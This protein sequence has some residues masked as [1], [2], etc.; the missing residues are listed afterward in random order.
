MA[1]RAAGRLVVLPRPSPVEQSP[2]AKVLAPDSNIRDQVSSVTSDF[3]ACR[4]GVSKPS[5]NQA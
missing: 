1:E 3:A 4:S 5:L 2:Q